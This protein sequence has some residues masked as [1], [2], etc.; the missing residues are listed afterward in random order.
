MLLPLLALMAVLLVEVVTDQRSRH[1]EV[2]RNS[3]TRIARALDRGLVALGAMADVLATSDHLLAGDFDAFRARVQQL[4]RGAE[5]E[6]VVRDAYGRVLVDSENLLSVEEDV[7]AAE[8]ARA[9]GRMRVSGYLT[10]GAG[11]G[12]VFAVTVPVPDAGLARGWLL[13]LHVPLSALGKLLAP[14]DVPAGMTATITARDGTILARSR[15]AARHVG[16]RP[17]HVR[18]RADATEWRQGI[19]ADGLPIV[20]ASTPVEVAGWT[21]WVFLPETVF[22]APLRRSLLI[23]SVLSLS[24]AGLAI[25]LATTFAQRISQPL[26][27]LSTAVMNGNDTPLPVT[28]VQE[29]NALAQAFKAARAETRK[30]VR[31]QDQLLATLDFAQ[32][33]VRA[34]DGRIMVWTSGMERLTGW[35]RS[36]VAGRSSHEVLRTEFPT[37]PAAIEEELLAQGE[38]QG[39]LSYRR[40]D[41]APIVVASHW[42]LHR[43]DG[44]KALAVVEACTDVTALREAEH[45]LRE[46]QADLRHVARL[47]EMGAV[48]AALAHEVSQP[49]TAASSFAEAALRLLDQAQQGEMELGEAREAMQEAADQAVFAGRVVRR[50]RDFLSASGQDR[51]AVGLNHVVREAVALALAG[52]VKQGVSLNLSLAPGLPP[53]QA[54]AVQIQQAVVNL[55][56]NAVAAMAGAATRVLSVSTELAPPDAVVVRIADTGLG[57]SDEV[58]ATLFTPFATTRREGMGIGLSISRTI[59]EEHGG[60]LSWSS[61]PG[62]GSTFW[63]TLPMCQANEAKEGEALHAK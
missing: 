29:C 9:S 60:L 49:L 62:E 37:S 7:T 17:M 22:A 27:M 33:I 10:T 19:D 44:G 5:A 26:S 43:D 4:P 2:A 21:A 45:R 36:E 57:I 1:E 24:V 3:A 55:T 8:Q 31:T 46:A 20:L 13:S 58:A 14:E 51:A 35:S 40:R 52:S 12:P 34:P 28:R 48:A 56:R 11:T 16:T 18:P 6:V 61:E 25:L 39:E 32:I 23:G 47:N 42:A 15:D 50:L 53:V 38:W 59:V 63:F 41:G 30:H 54:D